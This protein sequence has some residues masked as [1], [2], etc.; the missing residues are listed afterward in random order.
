MVAFIDE[1]D[2]KEHFKG[3]VDETQLKERMF[4]H[5]VVLVIPRGPH[6]KLIL[7]KRA[8]HKLPFPN[9]WCCAVGGKVHSGENEEEAARREMREEVGI[10]TPLQ[11]VLS[12]KYNEGDYKAFFTVFT[13]AA[14]LDPQTFQ[15]NQDEVQY[16]QSFSQAEILSMMQADPHSFAPTF[17]AAITKFIE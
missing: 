12:F 16:S 4:F 2:E 1:L 11:K 8:M 10:N 15:V 3:I 5:K 13:T 9:T 7:S 17:R 14:P 6:G